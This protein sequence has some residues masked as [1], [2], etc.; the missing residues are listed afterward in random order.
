M[1]PLI[2]PSVYPFDD[3]MDN[4][5]AHDSDKQT[6]QNIGHKNHPLPAASL[7]SGNRK[8]CTPEKSKKQEGNESLWQ[9]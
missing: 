1:P 3:I 9:D 5:A 2:K 6:R 7:G 8:N 4:Y